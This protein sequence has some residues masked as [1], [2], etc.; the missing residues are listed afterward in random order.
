LGISQDN[1]KLLFR[2]FGKIDLGDKN[3][4]NANGVGLGLL[5]SHTLALELAPLDIA[6]LK[7]KSE[8]GRGS[9]FYF[10]IE[11]RKNNNVREE[12]LDSNY[13]SNTEEDLPLKNISLVD[14]L[15]RKTL[16]ALG[17]STMPEGKFIAYKLIRYLRAFSLSI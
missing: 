12:N 5:I 2:E 17:R 6:G 15:S 8:E 3:V 1:Q 14:Q 4:F 9:C 7:V 16:L 11:D 13:S 10:V